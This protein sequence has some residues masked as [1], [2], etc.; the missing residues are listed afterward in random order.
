MVCPEFE[1]APK[2]EPDVVRVPAIQRFNGSDF[3]V[4]LVTPRRLRAAVEAFAPDITH[5]NHPFLLGATAVRL[6]RM[7]DVPLVF[8]HHTMYEHY[9][10]YVSGD[11]EAMRR[12][13]VQLSTNYANLSDAVLAPSELV[14]TILRRRGVGVPIH[15][16]PTGVRLDDFEAGSG[17]GFRAI[18]GLL[19]GAFVVGHVGRLAPEKNLD[20]LADG[21][22][23]FLAE[24]PSAHALI[25]GGGPSMPAMRAALQRPGLKERVHFAGVLHGLFLVS[26]YKAMDAFAFAS[27]SETQGMV[28]VEAMAASVPV[29]ALAAPGVEE[30]VCDGINGRVLPN[31]DPGALAAA[32]CEIATL[33]IEQRQI[34]RHGARQTAEAYSLTRTGDAA[35]KVYETLLTRS[36]AAKR[37]AH[38]AW[39]RT[40]RLLRSEWD[41]L[42]GMADAAVAPREDERQVEGAP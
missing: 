9:T 32:L 8:T 21:V 12:F 13:A 18:M 17:S 15:V 4:V 24:T 34:L 22:A 16:V 7:L 35:I 40:L 1:N 20:F 42:A 30:V 26:A 37:E 14:A 29:V 28:L 6:A 39:Q 23:G 41:L 19:E 11:S 27:L 25:V 36:R 5:S 38:D 10:H 31:G 2:Q 3:S 33:P